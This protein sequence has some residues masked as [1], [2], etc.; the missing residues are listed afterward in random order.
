MG[1]GFC[2]GYGDVNAVAIGQCLT[3]PGVGLSRH[4]VARVYAD[5]PHEIG[6]AQAVRHP[7]DGK[8][9]GFAEHVDVM[10][11]VKACAP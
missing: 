8:D 11:S 10:G 2:R 6:A 5:T 3:V 7:Q 9:F 1:L 4:R